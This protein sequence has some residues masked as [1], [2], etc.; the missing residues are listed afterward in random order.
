[1]A[2]L[3][4]SSVTKALANLL[5][6]YF[7]ASDIWSTMGTS[8]TISPQP[9]DELNI[10]AVG[11]Y[12]YHI[13]EDNQYKNLPAPGNDIPPVR[14]VPMGL[15]LF[16]QLTAHSTEDE[17]GTY[18]EQ[19][20][21][22]IAIKALHD[23]PII[24]DS[25][26][27]VDLSETNN[28]VFPSD[29][30]GNDNRL[31]IVLQPIAHNEAMNYWSAGNKPPRLAAYYQ[32]SVVLLEP[33][34]IQS[35]SSRV[36]T[37]GVQTFVEGA[38]RIDSSKNTLSFIIPGEADPREVELRPAQALP[39]KTPLP[40]PL[41]IDHK[42]SFI[43]SGLKV[44]TTTLLLKNERW[45]DP[46]EVDSTWWQIVVTKDGLNAVI[47]ETLSAGGTA[48]L[49]GIYSAVAKVIK[50]IV[51]P[52][53]TGRDIE[54]LSNQCPFAISPRIDS[55]GALDANN[56]SIIT[57]YT[58]QHTDISPEAVLAYFGNAKLESKTMGALN[59]GE[60]KVTGPLTLE[61]R[62]PNVDADGNAFESGKFYPIRVFVNGVESSPE[63]IE[64]P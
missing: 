53:G 13:S 55:I 36:L 31:R 52:N 9:P 24:D 46:Q 6:Y 15:N 5:K 27:I 43:G 47:R 19:K 10:D 41:P 12:L 25:T 7:M 64:Y 61:V 23:Y 16:Y 26:A 34:K 29:L 1:M 32:V 60:F 35:R 3:D 62:L 21:M 38:P 14:F 59:P 48:V 33:E 57:G 45:D 50:Q 2:L 30:Q 39:A 40:D 8:P 54:H 44:G 51:L 49:P 56:V 63:W 11:L 20:M 22:G 28:T 37:Y 17:T 58:F 18:K 4:L 42:I